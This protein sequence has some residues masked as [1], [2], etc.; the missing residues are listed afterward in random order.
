MRA[1]AAGGPRS[2]RAVA[3]PLAPRYAGAVPAAQEVC[4]LALWAAALMWR[5]LI[6]TEEQRQQICR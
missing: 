3:S 2:C 4:G 5:E 6:R 1:A